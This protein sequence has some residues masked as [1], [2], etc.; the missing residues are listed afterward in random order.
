MSDSISQTLGSGDESAMDASRV[1]TRWH[2]QDTKR[3]NSDE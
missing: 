1:E 2:K 3:R